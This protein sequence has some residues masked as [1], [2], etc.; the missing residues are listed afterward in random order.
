MFKPGDH[1]MYM[2]RCATVLYV[3]IITAH[4][5]YVRPV[6]GRS[7]RMDVYLED[8]VNPREPHV[9]V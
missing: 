3:Y 2:G 1:V 5:T 9:C 4:I 7:S 6:R 8:L